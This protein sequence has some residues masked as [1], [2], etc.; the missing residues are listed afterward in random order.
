LPDRK[1]FQNN[2][3]HKLPFSLFLLFLFIYFLLILRG[4]GFTKKL[5]QKPR[6]SWKPKHCYGGGSELG[7]FEENNARYL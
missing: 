7:E 4:L 3:K 6:V 5:E 2:L 1:L